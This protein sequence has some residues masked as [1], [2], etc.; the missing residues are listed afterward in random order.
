MHDLIWWHLHLESEVKQLHTD[1]VLGHVARWACGACEENGSV[2][3]CSDHIGMISATAPKLC[4]PSVDESMRCSFCHV[5]VGS[6]C[7]R[8][9]G[10]SAPAH[11]TSTGGSWL[12]SALGPGMR[13]PGTWCGQLL[14]LWVKMCTLTSSFSRTIAP[15]IPGDFEPC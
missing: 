8:S 3:R 13:Q 6:G 14:W 15:S 5:K 4:G 1:G 11:A 9:L 7:Y 10:N 12:S 2:L